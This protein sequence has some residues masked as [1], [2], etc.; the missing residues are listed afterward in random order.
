M[1]INWRTQRLLQQMRLFQALM[2]GAKLTPAKDFWA[3]LALMFC[4]RREFT[5]TVSYLL[6]VLNVN[7]APVLF[8]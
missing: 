4:D 5:D 6:T 1:A 7:D 3:Q 2:N 8:G